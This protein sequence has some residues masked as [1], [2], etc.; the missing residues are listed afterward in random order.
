MQTTAQ[1]VPSG[2]EQPDPPTEASG[3][4][5]PGPARTGDILFRRPGEQA[6][7]GAAQ[8]L[9]VLDQLKPEPWQHSAYSET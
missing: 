7:I 8:C 4:C 6:E 3:D 9:P 1:L 2:I 5:P